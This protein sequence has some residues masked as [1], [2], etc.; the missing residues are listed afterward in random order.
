L[1]R[2]DDGDFMTDGEIRKIQWLEVRSRNYDRL[3]QL[4][5]DVLGLTFFE[6]DDNEF[7]KSKVG[8]GEPT[9]PS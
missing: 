1:V 9:W 3:V 2:L 6:E 8:N 4:Y 5:R 7:I